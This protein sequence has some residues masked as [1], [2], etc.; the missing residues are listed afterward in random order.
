MYH[1]YACMLW[2]KCAQCQ[3]PSG[4]DIVVRGYPRD[5][6]RD[7]NTRDSTIST[8]HVLKLSTKHTNSRPSNLRA[9]G[10]NINRS[11]LV[12][13]L[14]ILFGWLFCVLCNALAPVPISG[15]RINQMTDSC[16]ECLIESR[17]FCSEL[18]YIHLERSHRTIG[19][20]ILAHASYLNYTCK[21]AYI[22]KN[23]RTELGQPASK[24]LRRWNYY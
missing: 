13:R 3:R 24:G 5:K 4:F 22:N 23:K 14:R 15:T 21:R 12:P 9:I 6:T 1:K 7:H 11:C 8:K 20:N 2:S 18:W 10:D 16:V 19:E 17:A